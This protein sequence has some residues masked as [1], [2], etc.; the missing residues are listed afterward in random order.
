MLHEESR[1]HWQITVSK[2]ADVLYIQ[3]TYSIYKKKRIFNLLHAMNIMANINITTSMINCIDLLHYFH[4]IN[5][6]PLHPCL[7]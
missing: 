5:D 7:F 1:W 4:F 2:T 3:P 6:P